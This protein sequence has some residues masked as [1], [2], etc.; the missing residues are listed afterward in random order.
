[1]SYYSMMTTFG[2]KGKT[3]GNVDLHSASSRTPI[4]CSDMDHT[5]LPANNTISAC[6]RKHSP[7]GASLSSTYYSCFD[8]KMMNG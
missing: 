6:T 4:M 5:V 2:D 8:P 7:G 1:M 3:K